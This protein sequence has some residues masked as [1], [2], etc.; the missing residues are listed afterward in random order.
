MGLFSSNKS[1]DF[2]IG[3]WV[4]V[5]TLGCSGHII[6][7]LGDDI[8]VD[9]GDEND[10]D[11]NGDGIF[12]RDELRKWQESQNIRPSGYEPVSIDN[13]EFGRVMWC[14]VRVSISGLF[15]MLCLC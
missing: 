11:E 14:V 1:D 5:K 12:R 10:D 15:V 3:D 8:Y 9:L 2:K 6:D 4:Y 13:A 7:I